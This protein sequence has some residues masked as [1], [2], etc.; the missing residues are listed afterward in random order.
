[1]TIDLEHPLRTHGPLPAGRLADLLGISRPTL[2]RAVRAAD[3]ALIIRG[4]ARRTTYA[5]RR[6]LRGSRASLPVFE[7]D[8]SGQLRD[9]AR[10]DL[11]HPHGCAMAYLGPF[12]WPMDAAMRDGWHE[13]LPYPLQ[14]MR[15]QGFLGR[16]LARHYAPVLQ[17]GDDP[18]SWSDDDALH[19]MSLLGDDTPGNLLV[20]EPACRRW[21][22]RVRRLKTHGP[23][24]VDDDALEAAYPTKASFVLLDGLPDSSAGGEFPKFTAL[25]RL[26]DG[27]HRHVIVKFS[28]NDDAPGTRRW[29]DLLVCEHLAGRVL[30]SHLGIPAA[31]SRIHRHGDRTFLEVDRFDRHGVLGRSPLV[32][33]FTLNATTVGS[34]G[35]PWHEAARPLVQKG[36]M[37]AQDLALIHRVWLFGRLIANNDM[38]DGNLSLRPVTRADGSVGFAP[39]PVYDMLPM[40]YAPLRGMELPPREYAPMLPMPSELD[41]WSAAADAA[42][43]FWR[44][45]AGDARITP[46][47]RALCGRNGD[48]LARSR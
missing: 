25:R 41:A 18:S 9:A 14:D 34:A 17:V 1:M 43:A 21:L 16:N 11:V 35:H 28:G 27:S 24:A 22:D 46:A 12:A 42:V 2:S 8:P 13:G 48:R 38:H 29:S 36:W 7:I 26:R 40:A 6:T 10:L 37:S 47:F 32:S 33:W 4:H 44:A 31:D 20:G 3:D 45:A 39:A 5:A 19:V 15:P 23:D 30:A